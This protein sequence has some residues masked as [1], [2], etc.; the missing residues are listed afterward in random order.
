MG[1]L[2][3]LMEEIKASD[4]IKLRTTQVGSTKVLEK[5]CPHC[6]EWRPLNYYHDN[7]HSGGDKKANCALCRS[8]RVAIK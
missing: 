8:Q 4:Y 3:T 1:L 2:Y 6:N 7:K 5:R